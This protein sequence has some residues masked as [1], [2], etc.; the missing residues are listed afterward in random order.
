MPA[1]N[2]GD[3]VRFTN[4]IIDGLSS[5]VPSSYYVGFK[6]EELEITKVEPHLQGVLIVHF[7]LLSSSREDKIHLAADGT[8]AGPNRECLGVQV[9]EVSRGR[10]DESIPRNNDGRKYCF[11]C[12][13]ST[14]K[15]G[16]GVY[17]ICTACGR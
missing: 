12:G 16:V 5:E 17:D 1:P 15:A 3:R 2:V 4:A 14:R 9:F 6:D 13:A 8:I 10:L 11:W 7:R